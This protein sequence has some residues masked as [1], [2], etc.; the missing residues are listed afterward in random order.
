MDDREL[1]LQPKHLQLA[2]KQEHQK[3]LEKQ[4]QKQKEKKARQ[5]EEPKEEVIVVMED[6]PQPPALLKLLE[7]LLKKSMSN[8]KNQK[9]EVPKIVLKPSVHPNTN[10]VPT[11]TPFN[12]RLIPQQ[13]ISKD[14]DLAAKKEQLEKELSKQ[15]QLKKDLKNKIDEQNKKQNQ[16]TKPKPLLLKPS[17]KPQNPFV[18]AAQQQRIEHSSYTKDDGQHLTQ[19]SKMQ[20]G[21]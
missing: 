9:Q 4:R 5:Q 11:P 3:K 7:W 20:I 2:L 6:N 10:Q 16:V 19:V 15:N 14:K 18:N 1:T 8:K 21:G 17:T 13:K 12:T